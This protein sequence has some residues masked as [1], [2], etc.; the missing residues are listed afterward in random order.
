MDLPDLL[1]KELHFAAEAVSD[2][3]LFQLLSNQ[4]AQLIDFFVNACEDEMWCDKHSQF[5]HLALDWISDNFFKERISH[6]FA[7]RAVEALQTHYKGLCHLIPADNRL[8]A[9]GVSEV[10]FYRI[11]AGKELF[12]GSHSQ[13]YKH[14]IETGR[15]DNLWRFGQDELLTIHTEAK[16]LGLEGFLTLCAD[17]IKRYLNR[18]NVVE[19]LI[20]SQAEDW[21]T[22][23]NHCIDLINRLNWGVNLKKD[24]PLSFEFLA[25][26]DESLALFSRLKPTH[27][28]CA[29]TE[30]S[31]FP[32]VLTS[33]ITS[34]DVTGS[35]SFDMPFPAGLSELNLS[36]CGWLNEKTIQPLRGLKILKLRSNTHL[37]YTFWQALYS[38]PSL[39]EL[40]ISHCHQI[41]DEELKIIADA[42]PGLQGLHMRECAGDPAIAARRC[43]NLT[44]LDVS[45][46]EI[47]D[48][49]LL[50]FATRCPQLEVLVIRRCAQLSEKGVLETIR[51]S[52]QLRIIHLTFS[53][54]FMETLRAKFPQLFID[55]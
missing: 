13:L 8:M 31:Q 1:P 21:T 36:M 6:A 9:G 29:L 43:P 55:K 47:N 14:Y 20:L 26:S 34:L 19:M 44:F 28:I 53:K 54:P 52:P 45:R 32:S 50:E 10:L 39:E 22:L 3:A 23:R 15:A 7:K 30:D 27:L 40:D 12:E 24:L 48:A 35:P 16:K 38:L 2:E 4:T 17:T 33:T 41:G 11:Q 5:F 49:S 46:T 18:E 25:F 51:L 37:L 42:S